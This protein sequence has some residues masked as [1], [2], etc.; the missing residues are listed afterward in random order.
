MLSIRNSYHSFFIQIIFN[1]FAI[2]MEFCVSII[3]YGKFSLC[4]KNSARETFG[5]TLESDKNQREKVYDL[6]YLLDEALEKMI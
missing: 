4:Q 1:I 2:M 5:V 3:G 6:S